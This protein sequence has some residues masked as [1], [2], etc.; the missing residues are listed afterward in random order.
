ME[1]DQNFTGTINRTAAESTIA[2]T[3]EPSPLRQRPNIVMIVLDDVGY[4]EF[5]CYGSD[6]E[7]PAL[8]GLATDGLRYANFHVTPLCSPTRTCLLT[9]RN[10]HS[11]GMG[12]VAEMVNGFPNTRG[13]VSREAANLAEMLRPHGYQTLAAGKWHLG[14]IHETSP[15]G[16][17]DHW[18]LQRGF[19][20]FHGFLAGETNQWNPE[21][22]TG[23]ERVE[24]PGREGYHL[25]EDIVDQSCKWLRQLVSADPDRPFFLY[26]AFAAGHS[27]H[28]VPASYVAKYKGKFDGGWDKTRERILKRQKASGLLPEDQR[29]APRNPGV[30][31]WDE[32]DADEKRLAARLMEVYA[33][34]LDHADE[35]IA[36]LLAQIDAL[37]K[38]DDTI[39]IA[40]SDNGAS[41][42]GGPHGTYD[43]QRSRIGLRPSVEE[44]LAR[45]DDMGGPLTYN[46]YPFGWA[47]AGNT[48]FKRYKGHTYGGGVRAPLLIR[49]PDGI[50]AK[51][52]TR[53]QFYHVVDI[54]PT[55]VDLLGVP[56]PAQVN[57][58][59]QVPLHGVSMA[60]TFNDNDADTRKTVQY[61][62][63]VGHRG[64]WHDGWKAVTFHERGTWISIRMSGNSINL[65]EDL[66]EIDDLADRYPEKLAGTQE[67]LVA[68][69]RAVWRASPGRHKPA[70][71]RRLVAGAQGP[72]GAVPGRGAAAPFQGTGPRVRGVSH[73]ITARIERESTDQDGAIIADGGRFGGWSVFIRGNR[74]HY[75]TNNFGARCRI[76]S[77]T[78]IPP[79]AVTLRADVVRTGDDEGRVRFYVDD[80]PA[81]EGV[82]SPF[83]YHNFVNEPLDVGRDSQT[84]VDD[85]Y[86]SPFVF[87][88]KIVNVVI[89]AFG[90]EAV[91]Q[92]VLLEELMASQ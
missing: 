9:G 77:P 39:V 80:E 29:L 63:M 60:H 8:D 20:R 82:L 53:R 54:T 46:H 79:G 87:H 36:R 28:H 78:A 48:P 76:S 25:S 26:V 88:G 44:N 7:T 42:L 69:G 68:G 72:L 74:L 86:E 64:I 43:H 32:L 16:P 66:A 35:Q 65:D 70:V 3:S 5:G 71:K 67:P 84:P 59:G 11:V 51:G 56:L 27:P 37:G 33:G 14:S 91:D 45:F 81:G 10:H 55:L 57:G 18:P 73:R 62:E 89:E 30:Q 47:M 40:I 17:Y 13:F 85:L 24:P 1:H 61:F 58:V 92:E 75:T 19:D 34:F 21:L 23:N 31:V 6:I 22:I 15:A 49:W 83:G 4:A 52:E 41:P 38:R 90:T 12:R 2:W 50:R